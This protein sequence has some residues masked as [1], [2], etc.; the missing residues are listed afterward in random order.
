[1][2]KIFGR[3][4]NFKKIFLAKEKKSLKNEKHNA[5]CEHLS[6]FKASTFLS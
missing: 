2:L 1:M 4:Q 3:F 6:R 5:R